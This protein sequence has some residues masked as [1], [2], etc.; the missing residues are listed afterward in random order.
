MQVLGVSPPTLWGVAVWGTDNWGVDEDVWTDTDH[1]VANSL[2]LTDSL[3]IKE[4]GH[5]VALGT[6]GI[7]SDITSLLR[8]W[9]I[10]DYIYAKPTTDGDDQVTDQFSKVSDATDAFSKVSDASTTWTGV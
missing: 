10:W 8:E 1:Q 6:M 7:S 2:T 9:G 3:P 5:L 4:Y